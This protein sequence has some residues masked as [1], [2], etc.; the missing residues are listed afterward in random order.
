M[1]GTASMGLDQELPG[2]ILDLDQSGDQENVQYR[3]DP[4]QSEGEEPDQTREPSSQ[5]KAVKSEKAKSA[6]EP[7]KIGYE[8]ALH[9]N[10][11][12]RISLG[13]LKDF[14]GRGISSREMLR[15]R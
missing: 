12:G 15:S 14:A 1:V 4:E 6:Q 7:E 10:R 5:I 2:E 13:F 3:P 11:L 8:Y 9:G